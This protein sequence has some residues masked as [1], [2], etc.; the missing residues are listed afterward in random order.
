LLRQTFWF[1]IVKMNNLLV[2]NVSIVVGNE[3]PIANDILKVCLN[4]GAM[5]IAP[6]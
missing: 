2:N 4:E 1:D 5:A 6:S 3:S